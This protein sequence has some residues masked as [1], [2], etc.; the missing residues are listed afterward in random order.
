MA[1]MLLVINLVLLAILIF[2]IV[3]SYFGYFFSRLGLSL[4]HI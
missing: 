1:E 2:L 3:L 4:I